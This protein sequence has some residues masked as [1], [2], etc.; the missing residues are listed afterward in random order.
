[1]Q[2]D[3]LA[4]FYAALYAPNPAPK[5]GEG[6]YVPRGLVQVGLTILLDPKLNVS[7]LEPE[8]D[9]DLASWQQGLLLM[10]GQAREANERLKDE[11][12]KKA[13]P[14]GEY[15]ELRAMAAAA[16]GD[17]ASADKFLDQAEKALAL[18]PDE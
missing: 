9:H 8:K 11:V 14:G 12:L 16:L 15:E 3:P 4:R 17:Y 10:T 2:P 18:P 1:G 6:A 7:K 13:L 5:G